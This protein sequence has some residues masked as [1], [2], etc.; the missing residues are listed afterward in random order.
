MSQ[1]SWLADRFVCV[2]NPKLLELSLWSYEVS[3]KYLDVV[4]EIRHCN[5]VTQTKPDL[6]AGN[7]IE[8]L[9]VDPPPC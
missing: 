5:H 7:I 8:Q 9:M 6:H 2:L 1:T 4:N 3:G